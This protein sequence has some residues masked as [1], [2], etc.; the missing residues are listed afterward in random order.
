MSAVSDSTDSRIFTF[1]YEYLC[2]FET[3]FEDI[4]GCESGAHMGSIHKKTRGK[5]SR[6]N[7]P[8]KWYFT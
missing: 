8:L 1:E 7:V 6:A 4:L 2:E 5:K 3:K